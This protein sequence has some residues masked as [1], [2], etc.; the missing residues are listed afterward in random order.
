KTNTNFKN[1]TPTIKLVA[2][3][4]IIRNIMSLKIAGRSIP[5]SFVKFKVNK[6]HVKSG[7]NKPAIVFMV[8][9]SVAVLLI[10]RSIDEND[11][12]MKE[13]VVLTYQA[14][15]PAPSFSFPEIPA[16]MLDGSGNFSGKCS[17]EIK[18]EIGIE[19]KEKDLIDLTELAY[20]DK[21]RGAYPSPGGSDE[22]LKLFLCIKEMKKEDVEKLEGKLTGLKDEGENIT[23]RLIKLNEL[24]KIPDMKALSALALYNALKNEGKI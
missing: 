3:N 11:P 15:I 6:K 8:G 4:T 16:G 2:T 18:E 19:I 14:R 21:F 13:Q 5:V 7:I 20:G 17:D 10:L 23:V 9:G 24:W 22:F 1:T 12:T